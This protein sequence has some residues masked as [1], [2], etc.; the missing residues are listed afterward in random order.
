MKGTKKKKAFD[1]AVG[2]CDIYVTNTPRPQQG[3]HNYI[4]FFVSFVSS[5]LRV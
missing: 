5:S 4:V 3:S 1:V 2:N